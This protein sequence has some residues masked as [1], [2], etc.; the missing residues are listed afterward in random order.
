M[1]KASS[2]SRSFCRRP[3]RMMF[4]NFRCHAIHCA[5]GVPH[6]AGYALSEPR[7]AFFFL[8]KLLAPTRGEGVEARFA[9]L[10][11]HAPLGAYPAFLLHAVKRG[12]KRTFFHAQ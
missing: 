1:W 5:S 12:I 9:V 4:R 3:G 7:P 10:F 6:H 11:G 2:R 8:C